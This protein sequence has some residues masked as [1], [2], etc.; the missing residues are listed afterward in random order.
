MNPRD[1]KQLVRRLIEEEVSTGY[2]FVRRMPSTHVWQTL[3]YLDTLADNERDTLVDLW[4]ERGTAMLMPVRVPGP[5]P[6]PA[7]FA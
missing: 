7:M 4:A 2:D 6:I 5:M 3:A 1:A